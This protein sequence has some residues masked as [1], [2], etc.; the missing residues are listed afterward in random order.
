[1]G[2]QSDPKVTQIPVDGPSKTYGIY[3]VGAT[4]GYFGGSWTIPFVS[5]CFA[6]AYFFRF[7]VTFA[8]RGVKL[9][10]KMECSFLPYELQVASFLDKAPP[11]GHS[12]ALERSRVQKLMPNGL[13]GNRTMVQKRVQ[14]GVFD[15]S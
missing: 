12:G 9:V 11:S 3:C 15:E 2:P 4:L 14:G 8:D 6:G 10:P 1:M 13:S 5:V 7:P